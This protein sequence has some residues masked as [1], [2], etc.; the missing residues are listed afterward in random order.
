MRKILIFVA[1][2][3]ATSIMASEVK[4][5]KNFETA[6]AEAIKLDRPLLVIVSS[7]TCYYCDLFKKTALK[8]E[9]VVED[10]NKNFVSVIAYSDEKDFIPRELLI[11]V[12]PAIW[13]LKPSGDV[14]FQPIKGAVDK[15]SFFTALTVVKKEF[16]NYKKSEKK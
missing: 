2:L 10:L 11:G 9:R 15:E 4:L 16:E 8:D 3:V 5:A 7:H 13:F 12:T 1:L 6:I 14:M